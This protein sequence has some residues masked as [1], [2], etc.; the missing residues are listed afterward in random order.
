MCNRRKSLVKFSSTVLLWYVAGKFQRYSSLICVCLQEYNATI[1]FLWAPLLVD[2][3]SDDPVNHR[4]DERIMRPDS[5]LKHS[6]KWEHADILVFNSYLWW[7]QGP[8]KLLWVLHHWGFI[9][10]E[11]TSCNAVIELVMNWCNNQALWRLQMECWREWS[12]WRI[13]RVR[14]YG[15]GYGGLGWLGGF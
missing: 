14:S 1:E 11:D 6:S 10:L 12:L 7:R 9:I 5:V 15:V 13:R 8:V 3:N 2:S 4:L